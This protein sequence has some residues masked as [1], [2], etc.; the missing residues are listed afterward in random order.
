[1]DSLVA[2]ASVLIRLLAAGWSLVI[3]WRAQDWRLVFLPVMLVLMASQPVLP[4]L[5]E[6]QSLVLQV[7]VLSVFVATIFYFLLRQP[8]QGSKQTFLRLIL[9]FITVSQTIFVVTG[10]FLLGPVLPELCTDSA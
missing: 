9:V 8:M 2:I 5:G 4:H 7:S 1:M 10:E 3:V 6:Q